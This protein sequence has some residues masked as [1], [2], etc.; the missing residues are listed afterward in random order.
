MNSNLEKRSG[1]ALCTPEIAAEQLSK[2]AQLGTSLRLEAREER[3][4][5]EDIW[6]DLGEIQ[7][8]APGDVSALTS[9]SEEDFLLSDALLNG[10]FT[11]TLP[12]EAQ[13]KQGL[14]TAMPDLGAKQKNETDEQTQLR[15]DN[16]VKSVSET[17]QDLA[18]RLG[19][20][21]PCFA[22][23]SLR[24]LPYARPATWI[25]DTSAIA[26]GAADYAA[27]ISFPMV[28]LRV[29]AI[30]SVE[31]QNMC[32]RFK[33]IW[34]GKPATVSQKVNCLKEHLKSQ[35]AQRC[36]MRLEWQ[37][38]VEIERATVGNDPLRFVFQNDNSAEVRD[39]NLTSIQRSLA[40]RLIFET[41]KE[42]RNRLSPG[43]P[44]FIVTSDGG[45]ARMALSEGMHPVYFYARR[46]S[47]PLGRRLTGTLHH[48]FQGQIYTVS[49]IDLL[50]ELAS[51]FG[52]A[53]LRLPD[54]RGEFGATAMSPTLEWSPD[55]IK[56]NLFHCFWT[57]PEVEVEAEVVATSQTSIEVSPEVE[58][59][60]VSTPPVRTAEIL[61]GGYFVHGEML[62]LL[63]Q[64]LAA[65]EEI[66]QQ[67]LEAQLGTKTGTLNEYRRFLQSG[68][69][70]S[71]SRSIW[72]PLEKIEDLS[73]AFQVVDRKKVSDL[74]CEI[75]SFCAFVTYAQQEGRTFNWKTQCPIQRA[76]S[77]YRDLAESCGS[78]LVIPERG[79]CATLAKPTLQEFAALAIERYEQLSR[80]GSSRWVETGLWLETLAWEDGVAPV[81]AR[82][83]LQQAFEANLL[84]R[85]FEGSTP[86][87]GFDDHNLC[88]L[89]TADGQPSFKRY[90][91][92]R[93]DFLWSPR[94]SVRLSLARKTA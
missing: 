91:I 28:R 15:Q 72:R 58:T 68:D 22:L 10:Q 73:S 27:R 80:R 40:D 71:V 31:I 9:S 87:V 54:G 78:T 49:L 75:P 59:P 83:L 47:E 51:C 8:V 29:P 48:P 67:E 25:L 1:G 26:Q 36:L 39:L 42:H 82:E 65:T 16:A 30:A 13:L 60:L 14:L 61:T 94:S 7:W 63:C 2:V 89:E 24:E 12:N 77:R 21:H 35:G 64:I 93:G 56:A 92:Y 53:R 44:L 17:L 84:E 32:D 70:I 45:M 79:I 52:V 38:A 66:S 18:R 55:H 3:C 81:L 46:G 37:S 43:Q 23:D 85:F 86:D 6:L 4:F 41:A 88:V 69:F 33:K 76:I 90:Y 19:L 62:V 5:V 20:L 74:L 11:W 34:D 57:L 50:W